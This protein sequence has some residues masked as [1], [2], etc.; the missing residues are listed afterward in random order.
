[1]PLRHDEPATCISSVPPLGG[2]AL[3]RSFSSPFVCLL[4]SFNVKLF[5]LKQCLHHTFRF[6]AVFALQH[7]AQNSGNDLPRKAVF[8]FKPATSLCVLITPFGKF[9]PIVVY[10]FLRLATDLE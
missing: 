1:M 8:V 3:A 10:F 5:H 7:L 9:L 4:Q 2:Y 6:L